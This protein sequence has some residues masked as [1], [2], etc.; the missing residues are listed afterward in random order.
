MLAI[1]ICAALDYDAA[2]V[3]GAPLSSEPSALAEVWWDRYPGLMPIIVGPD[4]DLERSNWQRVN[5][6]VE[7]LVRGAELLQTEAGPVPSSSGW[8]ILFNAHQ[9]AL[10]ESARASD[11]LHRLR[12]AIEDHAWS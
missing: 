10:R 3:D 8:A 5:A 1:L 2:I 4:A 6:G 9:S 12:A 7:A 11:W